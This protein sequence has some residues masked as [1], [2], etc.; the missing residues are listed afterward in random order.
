MKKKSAK[1]WFCASEGCEKCN[2]TGVLIAPEIEPKK[3]ISI[4]CPHLQWWES[5]MGTTK[6]RKCVMCPRTEILLNGEW[7]KPKQKEEPKE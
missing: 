5:Q 6:V 3:R 4:P 1:C 7:I 2:F